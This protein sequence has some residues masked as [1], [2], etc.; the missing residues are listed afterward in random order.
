MPFIMELGLAQKSEELRGNLAEARDITDLASAH[1]D[2]VSQHIGNKFC[3]L[4]QCLES[5]FD[6]VFFF[7]PR[8]EVDLFLQTCYENITRLAVE[9]CD[10]MCTV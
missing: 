6:K 10:L 7:F 1:T 2:K 5:F 4:Q 3:N 9:K 8:S